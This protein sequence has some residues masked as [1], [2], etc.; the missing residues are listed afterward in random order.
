MFKKLVNLKVFIALAFLAVLVGAALA[1]SDS[2]SAPQAPDAVRIRI[3]HLAPFA[4]SST[5]NMTVTINGN[6]VGGAIQYSEWIDY[7]TMPGGPGDYTVAAFRNGNPFASKVFTLPDGD[8]TI[9]IIGN[10]EVG[11]TLPQLWHYSD[12]V[13]P[14]DLGKTKLRVVHVA[15]IGATLAE[16]SVDVCNQAGVLFTPT[17]LDLRYREAT[18]FV[19][20]NP[21]TYDFKM[22]RWIDGALTPCT[23]AVVIDPIPITLNDGVITTMFLVGDNINQEAQ[24]FTFALGLIPNDDT[25]DPTPTV[26]VPGPTSTPTVEPTVGPT[27]T[28]SPTIDPA[29]LDEFSFVPAIFK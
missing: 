2:P 10:L 19:S 20:F 13:E 26:T 5:D 3:V 8:H 18:I 23:G 28:P 16:T 17:A 29:I 27:L 11:G 4:G 7:Q 25:P 22:T 15:S 1:Q 24:A 6:P 21:G 12:V 14:P 9:A